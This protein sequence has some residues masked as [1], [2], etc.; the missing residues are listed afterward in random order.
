MQLE[1]AVIP[2]VSFAT[3]VRLSAEQVFLKFY[4]WSFVETC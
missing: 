2:Y 4:N 3:S 1:S